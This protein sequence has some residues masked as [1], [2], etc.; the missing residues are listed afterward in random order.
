MKKKL[1]PVAA[2]FAVMFFSGLATDGNKSYAGPAP[3]AIG[4]I[5]L[6][7]V[8]ANGNWRKKDVGKCAVIE[9]YVHEN[10]GVGGIGVCRLLEVL[11]D[12]EDFNV[13]ECVSHFKRNVPEK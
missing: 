2:G 4:S 1:L 3:V 8:A 12:L 10:P 9:L 6:Q 5:C 11:F 7:L 13:G